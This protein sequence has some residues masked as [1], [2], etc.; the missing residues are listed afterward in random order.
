M[1][2]PVEAR[3]LQP[4]VECH[5]FLLLA[6]GRG[7][8]GQVCGRD[9]CDVAGAVDAGEPLGREPVGGLRRRAQL[10]RDD[11]G[12]HRRLARPVAGA[13]LGLR[14]VEQHC[15]GGHAVALGQLPPRDAALGVEARRVDHGRQPPA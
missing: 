1:A 5:R 10:G 14:R 15:V 13:D 3:D 2:R 11:L 9:E 4:E 12:R 8:G 6:G 7:R